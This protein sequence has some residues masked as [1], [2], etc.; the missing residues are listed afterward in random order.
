[1]NAVELLITRLIFGLSWRNLNKAMD[2]YAQGACHYNC[3]ITISE[4]S[5]DTVF[6]TT[7]DCRDGT[8]A[9]A[10][11][12]EI[13]PRSCTYVVAIARHRIGQRFHDARIPELSVANAAS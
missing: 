6:F 11:R 8:T 1:M 4:L 9:I 2:F 12:R 7:P 5:L 10:R 13:R 3:L